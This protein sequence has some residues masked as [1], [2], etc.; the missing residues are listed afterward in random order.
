VAIL[1]WGGV[2]ATAFG[3]LMATVMGGTIWMLMLPDL[4]YSKKTLPGSDG[5][6]YLPQAA[7]STQPTCPSNR[8][9]SEGL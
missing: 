4:S 1:L 8:I 6:E 9:K 5:R 7:E 3:V 2:K